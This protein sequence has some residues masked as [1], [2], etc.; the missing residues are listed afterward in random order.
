MRSMSEGQTPG[1][2]SGAGLGENG[3]S[4]A[5]RVSKQMVQFMSRYTGRGPTKSRTTL[6]TNLATVV[7]DDSLTKAE[8]NLVAAGEIDSVVQQRRTFHRMMH[9]EVVAAIEE[10]TGRQV[11]AYL[12][13]I[14]PEVGVAVHVFI[15]EPRTETGEVYYAEVDSEST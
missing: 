5:A 15:F 1:P 7:L 2:H 4:V 3:Y 11:R 6:N 8:A 14:A 12:T 10:E 13:D 9:A